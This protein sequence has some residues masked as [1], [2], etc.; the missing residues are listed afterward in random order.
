M[1]QRNASKFTTLEKAMSVVV[2]LMKKK[3]N[4][5]KSTF[6]LNISKKIVTMYH[7]LTYLLHGEEL[8]GCYRL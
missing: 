6:H 7:I 3:K 8:L 4:C 1:F 2:P 5:Q